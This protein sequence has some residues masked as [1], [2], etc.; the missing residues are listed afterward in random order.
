M[1]LSKKKTLILVV[2]IAL[3]LAV[4]GICIWLFAFYLPQ[5]KRT[6]KLRRAMADYYDAK[7]AQFAEENATI[8]AGT[9]DVVFLGD[10]LTD[11][12]DV[13]SAYPQYAV[14]NRGIGGDTTNGLLQRL[15]VS[16]Y[17]VRPKVVV[18]LIGA[19]NMHTMLDNYEDLVSGLRSN[20]P[21]SK[22]VLLSLTSMSG[23]WGRNNREA[24]YN[25]TFIKRWAETYGC[26]FVDLYT[27]LFDETTGGLRDEYSVDGG[28]LTSAGYQVLTNTIAPV[29]SS[30]LGY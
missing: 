17:A 2:S 27:P 16:A 24:A 14:L 29:L 18:M 1:A 23:N 6:M 9:V 13:K 15:D 30:L 12:Y 7:V 19:N 8:E 11:G 3:A 21:D 5:A 10:S 20:L 22:V 25:N 26:T 4:A 28:H